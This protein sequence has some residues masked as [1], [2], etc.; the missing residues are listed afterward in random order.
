MSAPDYPIIGDSNWHFL[1]G[2]YTN[3]T[4]AGLVPSI[5]IDGALIRGNDVKV[6]NV[7]T[8]SSL[9]APITIGAE[10]VGTNILG[11]P[12]GIMNDVRIYNRAL[13]MQEI[14]DLYRWRGQP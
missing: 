6:G 10:N 12:W 2:E 8:I 3:T 7:G 5:Y 4:S 9:N 11:S 1:V 13:S 14:Q